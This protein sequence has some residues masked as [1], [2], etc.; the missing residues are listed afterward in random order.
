MRCDNVLV[1]LK[2]GTDF[3]RKLTRYEGLDTLL[4]VI[5]LSIKSEHFKRESSFLSTIV[6]TFILGYMLFNFN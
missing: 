3:Y 1:E 6:Y 5:K 4:K 2:T